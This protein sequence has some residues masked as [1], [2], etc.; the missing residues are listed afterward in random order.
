MNARPA[1]PGR[2]GQCPQKAHP[3]TDP[4]PLIAT[5]P[6]LRNGQLV[7]RGTAYT[8]SPQQAQQDQARGLARFAGETPTPQPE[9]T[10]TKRPRRKPP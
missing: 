7:P 6:F 10:P 9:S 3:M 4:V 1:N 2:A 8:A 5:R